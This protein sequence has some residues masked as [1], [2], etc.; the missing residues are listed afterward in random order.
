MAE[1]LRTAERRAIMPR[2]LIMKLAV[3]AAA[4]FAGSAMLVSPAMADPSLKLT[5]DN[6]Q[7]INADGSAQITGTYTCTGVGRVNSARYAF[8]QQG[9]IQGDA[10]GGRGMVTCDGAAHPYTSDVAAPVTFPYQLGPATV[11]VTWDLYSADGS[12]EVKL[13]DVPVTLQL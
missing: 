12:T 2:N 13:T 4:A 5:V 6:K 11:N 1:Y 3:A 8:L 7:H 10:P 9:N